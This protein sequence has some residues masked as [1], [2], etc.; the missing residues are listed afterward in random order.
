MII[1][2]GC[3]ITKISRFTNLD[4]KALEKILTPKELELY[5]TKQGKKKIEFLAGHFSAKESIIKALYHQ[6]KLNMLEIEILYDNEKPSC[7]IDNYQ[8][9]ISI[10]HDGE[11]A[12][13]YVT[14]LK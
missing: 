3:D 14:I 2:I 4:N 8:V 13:S 5:N 6:R 11:Y 12:L 1:G 10:S 7:K 9:L